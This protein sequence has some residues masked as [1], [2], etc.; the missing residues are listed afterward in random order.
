MVDTSSKE[1][2]VIFKQKIVLKIPPLNDGY[3][4]SKIM[5][6]ECLLPTIAIILST[7]YWKGVVLK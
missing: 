1:G 5:G 7:F 6:W 4:L 2:F 3:I